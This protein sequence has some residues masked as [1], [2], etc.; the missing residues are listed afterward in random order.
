MS[1]E[2]LGLIGPNGA[3]FRPIRTTRQNIYVNGSVLMILLP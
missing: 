2:V 3:G 1:D